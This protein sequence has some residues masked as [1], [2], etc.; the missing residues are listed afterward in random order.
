MV[1]AN[2]ESQVMDG[3]FSLSDLAGLDTD[4]I[5]ALTSR[6][7]MTGIWTVI[8]TKVALGMLPKQEDKPATPTIAWNLESINIEPAV[9]DP[10]LDPSTLA[11]R[12]ITDRAVIWMKTKSDFEEAIGLVKGKYQKAKFDTTGA[13]GG[14]SEH[15]QFGW[16]DNPVIEQRPFKI[17]VRHGQRNGQ[18]TAF[19]DWIGPADDQ[20]Q[21][22][23]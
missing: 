20:M 2:M 9:K 6:L 14:N 21:E 3:E 23:V 13:M 22:S 4:A 11:G 10:D 17:R 8:M 18:D 19:L 1:D 12:R 5:K 16:L 15:E 7:P